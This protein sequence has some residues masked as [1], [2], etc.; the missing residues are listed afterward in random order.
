MALI[1]VHEGIY[2]DTDELEQAEYHYFRKAES[3]GRWDVAKRIL[4]KYLTAEEIDT[5]PEFEWLYTP[6]EN[7]S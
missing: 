6:N 7:D 3:M 1:Q 5:N 2:R 4:S